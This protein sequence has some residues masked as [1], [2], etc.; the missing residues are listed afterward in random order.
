[1][2]AAASLGSARAAAQDR[3]PPGSI[4]IRLIEAPVALQ[5]DPR[6]HVY[7]ID[8]LHQGRTIR[9]RI[10]VSSGLDHPERLTLYA[11]GATVARGR[12]QF[13]EGRSQDEL[14][15]WITV[16][17]RSVELAPDGAATATV[18]IAVP[19]G[20]SD[21]ER[22][23][24]VWA[25]TPPS[26]ATGGGVATVNRVGIRVYLSVGQGGEPPVDFRIESL[27]ALRDRSGR[28]VVSASVVNTGGRAIDVSGRLRLTDGPG[29]TSAGPFEVQTGA[30]IGIG[31]RAPVR[32]VLDP[33]LPPGPWTATMTLRSD[34][35]ER[36][37]KGRIVFPRRR[38]ARSAPTRPVTGG[39]HWWILVVV[40]IALAALGLWWL[41]F[42]VR[43]RRRE[44]ERGPRR[45]RVTLEPR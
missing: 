2:A 7:I 25:S 6:A 42:R 35:V 45:M 39:G 3:P 38:G 1:V 40:A 28:P 18:T 43:R 21:G 20:A 5:D 24:V 19:R 16:D 36:T 44:S 41:L 37:A 10:E 12:F 14:S 32:V 29:G 15:S 9:R 23:A 4:G 33:D 22:Y 17:P 27:T 8:H 30:T 26:V 11:A 31:Q 34:L 13:L